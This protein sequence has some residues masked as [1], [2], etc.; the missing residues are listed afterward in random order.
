[1][2]TGTHHLLHDV[3]VVAAG[4]GSQQHV[5]GLRGRVRVPR[6]GQ[7]V[8]SAAAWPLT[9]PAQSNDRDDG[10][11]TMATR[12]KHISARTSCATLFVYMK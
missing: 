11:S 4:L 6:L 2:I 3:I 10:M 8:G 9:V 7:K 5:G 1:M 12:I